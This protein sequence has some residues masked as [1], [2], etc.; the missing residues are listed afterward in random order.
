VRQHHLSHDDPEQIPT[1]RKGPRSL[2]GHNRQA[3]IQVGDLWISFLQC[4][5]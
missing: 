2:A 4:L 1:G 3:Q 5:D